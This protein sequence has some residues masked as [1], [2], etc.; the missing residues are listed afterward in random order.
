MI[1]F[2]CLPLFFQSPPLSLPTQLMF[3]STLFLSLFLLS[4][5]PLPLSFS[6][7]LPPIFFPHRSMD[8]SLYRVTILLHHGASPGLWWISWFHGRKLTF[9]HPTVS[10]PQLPGEVGLHVPHLLSMLVFCQDWA[11]TVSVSSYL[12]CSVWKTLFPWSHLSPLSLKIFLF[13]LST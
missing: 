9:S 12:P 8:S 5:F 6:P 11:C 3:I 1:I 13:S 2:I 4:S 10:C 7:L